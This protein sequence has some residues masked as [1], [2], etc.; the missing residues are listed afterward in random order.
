MVRVVLV[1]R[2]CLVSPGPVHVWVG[3]RSITSAGLEECE[4][5]YTKVSDKGSN[6]TQRESCRLVLVY[7]GTLQSLKTPPETNPMMVEGVFPCAGATSGWFSG[8][9]N[10]GEIKFSIV[11]QVTMR[12]SHNV[13]QPTMLCSHTTHSLYT[14]LRRKFYQHLGI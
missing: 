1:K 7:I 11:V 4:R 5:E 13:V 8:P 10:N 3:R 2:S 14:A 6:I 12:C 9:D